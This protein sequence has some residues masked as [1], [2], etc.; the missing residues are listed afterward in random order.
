MWKWSKIPVVN[1]YS[2]F[3]CYASLWWVCVLLSQLLPCIVE[4]VRWFDMAVL[5]KLWN[6]HLNS[7]TTILT[8]GSCMA[9]KYSLTHAAK[10]APMVQSVPSTWQVSRY[11][12]HLSLSSFLQ[13][14]EWF[15]IHDGSLKMMLCC[16]H[17]LKDNCEK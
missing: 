9:L 6:N 15:L 5:Q 17:F 2:V 14:L 16:I 12:I 1:L 4:V 11:F 3:E 13:I 10:L 8:Y 7:E